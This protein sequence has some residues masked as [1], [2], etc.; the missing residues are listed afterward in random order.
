[1]SILA[2]AMIVLAVLLGGSALL[3]SPQATHAS[4]IPLYSFS[5][6]ALPFVSGPPKSKVRV[7]RERDEGQIQ[8][9]GGRHQRSAQPDRQGAEGQKPVSTEQLSGILGQHL[10]AATS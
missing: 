6:G 9:Q 1:M 2:R 7:W 10:Q 8:H 5:V 4:S 3:L